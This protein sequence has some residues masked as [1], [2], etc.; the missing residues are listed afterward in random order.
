MN[1]VTRPKSN[2]NYPPNLTFS[3]GLALITVAFRH[4]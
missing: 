1:S 4:P 2:R 3:T